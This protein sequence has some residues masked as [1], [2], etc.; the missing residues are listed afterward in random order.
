[1]RSTADRIAAAGDCRPPGGAMP[2]AR[3]VWRLGAG[4]RAGRP[5]SR[6]SWSSQRRT[7]WTTNRNAARVMHA[8]TPMSRLAVAQ[9]RLRCRWQR[10][11]RRARSRVAQH[12]GGVRVA[13]WRCGARRGILRNGL[14]HVV[15]VD[16][17]GEPAPLLSGPAGFGVLLL[18]S[19]QGG[20]PSRSV[21][22]E[23][24]RRT[25]PS[26]SS[27]QSRNN[28]F[29]ILLLVFSGI[30]IPRADLDYVNDR[31]A[32]ARWPGEVPGVGGPAAYRWA[33]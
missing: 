3:P 13:G 2:S 1:M 25:S 16:P 10:R 28:P 17:F 18:F 7:S 11:H 9:R 14:D 5:A 31:L 20:P 19:G 26:R 21:P 12:P 8:P 4:T 6:R 30:E 24:H 22:D 33:T 23:G 15:R 32:D 29:P 27:G